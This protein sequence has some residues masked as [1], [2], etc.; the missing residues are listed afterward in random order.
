MGDKI[1]TSEIFIIT[2]GSSNTFAILKSPSI[3]TEEEFRKIMGALKKEEESK[4]KPELR[5]NDRL[6]GL[7][8]AMLDRLLSEEYMFCRVNFIEHFI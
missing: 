4:I 6:W 2:C 1:R 7:F 5:G 3:L 8:Q